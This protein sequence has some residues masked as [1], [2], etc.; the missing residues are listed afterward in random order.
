MLLCSSSFLRGSTGFNYPSHFLPAPAGPSPERSRGTSRQRGRP[1]RA[2]PWR[3]APPR[4]AD[5]GCPA[6]QE[7]RSEIAQHKGRDHDRQRQ[8]EQGRRN[9]RCPP[10]GPLRRR[11]VRLGIAR[12]LDLLPLLRLLTAKVLAKLREQPAGGLFPR[13]GQRGAHRL[14]IP[15]HS[16]H[17]Y[18]I[19]MPLT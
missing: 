8:H 9:G 1:A 14:R 7:G 15:L 12:R 2:V 11:A 16:R 5:S 3:P 6:R 18:W 17:R 19:F 10:I 13:C 4:P